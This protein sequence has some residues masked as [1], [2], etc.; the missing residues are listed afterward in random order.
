M[1]CSEIQRLYNVRD[2]NRKMVSV[3]EKKIRSEIDSTPNTP[4]A[5]KRLEVRV[6]ALRNTADRH[7]SNIVGLERAIV[8]LEKA[9]A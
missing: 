6:Q 3:V 9:A 7:R 1:Q 5:Q 2:W 8:E 4:K